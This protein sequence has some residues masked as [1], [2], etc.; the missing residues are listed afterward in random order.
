[1]GLGAAT[2]EIQT[3]GPKGK[4]GSA[5]TWAAA[6]RP[7]PLTGPS[8]GLSCCSRE[9]SQHLHTHA[10][11]HASTCMHVPAHAST[12]EQLPCA[13]WAAERRPVPHIR[14]G[15]GAAQSP[16][17]AVST[18]LVA[19]GMG[20]RRG[21]SH[22]RAVSPRQA[23]SCSRNRAGGGGGCGAGGRRA[24]GPGVSVPGRRGHHGKGASKNPLCVRGA[25]NHLPKLMAGKFRANKRKPRV[26]GAAGGRGAAAQQVT[27]P[28]AT[29]RL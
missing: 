5:E 9:G 27:E 7:G 18:H 17:A 10:H 20:V 21:R 22:R 24:A 23:P 6:W 15:A 29:A 11:A 25:R 28:Q 19:P 3:P 26:A 16:P 4:G 14:A 8:D 12:H 2:K 1:M 13:P